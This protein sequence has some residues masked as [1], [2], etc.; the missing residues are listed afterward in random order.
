MTEKASMFDTK[1]YVVV[2]IWTLVGLITMRN[3]RWWLVTVS[4]LNLVAAIVGFFF[5]KHDLET[6]GNLPVDDIHIQLN[7]VICILMFSQLFFVFCV[8]N[9]RDDCVVNNLL[10]TQVL[11]SAMIINISIM[12]FM[13]PNTFLKPFSLSSM[14]Y[15]NIVLGLTATYHLIRNGNFGGKEE[16]SIRLH[17]H[18][19][20]DAIIIYMSAFNL[21]AF[22]TPRLANSFGVKPDDQHIYLAQIAAAFKIGLA[23]ITQRA[24]GFASVDDKKS[25]VFFRIFMNVALVAN[26]A[27]FQVVLQGGK[28][29]SLI[30]LVSI[31]GLLTINLLL[32]VCPASLSFSPM[33]WRKC[34]EAPAHTYQLRS[35]TTTTT[36]RVTRSSKKN[37]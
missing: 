16:K 11:V 36:S 14:L 5:P 13:R 33:F 8:R 28:V 3:R 24:P 19:R 18:L 31:I 2:A 37:T 1:D 22:T 6:Q 12:T 10:S 30:R 7:R 21:L 9:T 32:A 4:L 15:G 23:F 20:L 27:Y 29:S 26:W 35:S 34:E 17:F 25:V